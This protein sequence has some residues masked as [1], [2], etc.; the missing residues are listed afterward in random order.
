MLKHRYFKRLAF[1]IL[2]LSVSILPVSFFYWFILV[3]LSVLIMLVVSSARIHSGFYIE[4]LCSIDKKAGGVVLSFDDGPDENST[5]R[6]LDLL[7]EYKAAGVF[8]VIG[9]KAEKFPDIIA[10]IDSRGHLIGAHTYSHSPMFDLFS[11]KRV[12]EEMKDTEDIINKIISK[13]VKLFRPPFGVTNPVIKKAVDYFGY[14]TV[15]W[16]L[17]S[18]DTVN[19][20]PDKIL[21]KIKTTIKEGGHNII[22]R[23]VPFYCRSAGTDIKNS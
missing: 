11:L 9:E 5:P 7:D 1:V 18:F 17:R 3:C 16:S 12:K 21:Q 10:D 15:G 20:K 23:Y 13:R 19:K 14:I 2:V 4:T 8:F 6:I 22:S